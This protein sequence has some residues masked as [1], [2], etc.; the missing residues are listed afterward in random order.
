[1]KKVI[2]L[3]TQ[4]NEAAKF[5]RSK[6]FGHKRLAVILLDNFVEIQLSS[7]INQKFQWDGIFYFQEKKYPHEKR[8]KILRNYDQL[9]STCVKEGI[10][11]KT[12]QSLIS[13]CHDVR[14]NLYH[15]G[16]EE[17][18][19]TQI[20][21]TI[22]YDLIIKYQ[23]VWKSARDF[24]SYSSDSV[25]PYCSKKKE[26]VRLDGNS[27][28]EWKY[29]LSKYFNCLDKRQKP[30]SKLLSDYLLEKLHETHTAMAFITKEFSIFFP[31]AEDWTFND[32]LLNYSFQNVMFDEIEMI[33]EIKPREAAQIKYNDLFSEYEKRW[34]PK[35]KRR[36]KELENS[37][38]AIARLSTEKSLE[39]FNSL[40]DEVIM[41]NVAFCRAAHDLDGAIQHAIDVARGK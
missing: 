28:G 24:T 36:L 40:K 14:N 25:D 39:K 1:M 31:Y 2:L 9:L 17:E 26:S 20:A 38:K 11:N 13:F 18:L 33:K 37:T 3:K 12:E 21:L 30:A 35:S 19:L 29:F 4:L 6:Y 8:K 32:F 23:P 15:K 27:E 10:I 41:I 5:A 16:N 22:L 34:R 7:L